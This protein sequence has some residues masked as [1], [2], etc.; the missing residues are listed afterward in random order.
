[1][2]QGTYVPIFIQKDI[3]GYPRLEAG[4]SDRKV[5]DVI[6]CSVIG[7]RNK[8]DAEALQGHLDS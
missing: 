4:P 6:F 3:Q 5:L 1:M 2:L 7:I 8:E